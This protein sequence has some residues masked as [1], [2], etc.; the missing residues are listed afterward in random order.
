MMIIKNY[1]K[2][3]L[4]NFL[5]CFAKVTFVFGTVVIVMNLLEEI[6]FFKDDNEGILL[7][8][9]FLTLLNM[10][11]ILFELFP[12]I[13]LISTLFFFIES[14]DNDE[15]NVFKLYGITNLKII[16]ILATLSFVIGL[17]IILFFYNISANLKF[18][19]FD[20]KNQY[21]KDDKYLAVVT[22]NGL[23]IRDDLGEII[24]YINAEKLDNNKLNNVTISQFNKEFE[25]Q[26]VIIS[27]SV[28]I[29]TKNWVIDRP[30]INLD[31]NTSTVE[32]LEFYSNFDKK[33]I[34]SIF[35]N[36][37]S[38]DMFKLETLREDYEM[39]GYNTDI[40]NGHK[41]R[42]FSYPLYLAIMVCIG[43]ILML[44]IG[45]NKSKI[46]NITIG[47]AVSV[48]IYYVNYFFNVI[49]ETQEVPYLTS[50]WGPQIILSM[51]IITN[52]IRINEK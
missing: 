14:I 44:N 6:N 51:I 47:I 24:N 49:I 9:I 1:N 21:S 13:F 48:V 18:F 30:I 15:I 16:Q 40:I 23:W 17:V 26:K 35:E 42:L 28:D 33:R 3:I 45:Y 25:L 38:L 12:F 37:S 41:H 22:G 36:L 2:Y 27:K 4:K 52:L 46:G 20:L 50:V 39:L 31:N 34:L 32:K 5:F 29:R 8:P 7:M 10:P 11:S 19:Y 43:A